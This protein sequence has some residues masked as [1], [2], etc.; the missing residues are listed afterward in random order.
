M[1]WRWMPVSGLKNEKT[2]LYFYTGGSGFAVTLFLS[3]GLFTN[4]IML[5]MRL[6]A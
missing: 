2:R 4:G 5:L 3:A 6:M 1:W